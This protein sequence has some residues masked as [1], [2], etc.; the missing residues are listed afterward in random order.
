MSGGRSVER[1]RQETGSGH[2]DSCEL[3]AD[4]FFSACLINDEVYGE[5]VSGSTEKD[6][7][8]K[9][10]HN[11]LLHVSCNPSSTFNNFLKTLEE[12]GH[13]E[14]SLTLQGYNLFILLLL[15]YV[16]ILCMQMKSLD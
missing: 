10:I 14:M 1:E 8:R 3:F 7:T 16:C 15:M 2:T 13:Q 5:V 12:N 9:L 4:S 11:I 6:N